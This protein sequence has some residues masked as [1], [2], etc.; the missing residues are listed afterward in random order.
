MI[1]DALKLHTKNYMT[2]Q[3]S[4]WL[5]TIVIVHSLVYELAATAAVTYIFKQQT[6]DSCCN[7]CPYWCVIS[8]LLPGNLYNSISQQYERLWGYTYSWIHPVY[9]AWTTTV[10]PISIL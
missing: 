5:Y 6:A 2:V 3:S 10:T 9:I 4:K 7:S 1:L 8:I